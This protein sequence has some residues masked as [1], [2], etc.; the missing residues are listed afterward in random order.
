MPS[1]MKTAVG[2]N[3]TEPQPMKNA[4]MFQKMLADQKFIREA[5]QKGISFDEL[6]EKYGYR[7]ATV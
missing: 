5:W 4:E 1:K 7:F 6:R 3:S 2:K